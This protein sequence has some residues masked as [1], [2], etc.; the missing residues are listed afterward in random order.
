MIQVF[1]IYAWMMI[2][3]INDQ[4]MIE[5][6]RSH[7]DRVIALLADRGM[8]RLA[9]LTATG[10][11]ATA[12]S[13]LERDGLILRLSRG[14]YQLADVPT[15]VHHALA[16]ASKLVP[17]GVVCLTSALAFHDLTDRMPGRVWMAITRADHTSR[18]I[19][20][21]MRFVRFAPRR[22]TEGVTR[23]GIE[24]VAVPIT[25]PT[26]TVVDMFRYRSVVGLPLAIEGLKEALRTR[27]VTPAELARIATC[28][29]AWS[30]MRPYL[31][32]LTHDG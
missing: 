32:A 25:N 6:Q 9:E 31:E 17:R 11:T 12:V 4:A 7:K 16:E 27:R 10:A 15:D 19:Q 18:T 24:G 26:Y 13:R 23:H 1:C 20:P 30:I 29:R 28:E 14:L 8:A 2:K 3:S 5:L 22:L 21:P